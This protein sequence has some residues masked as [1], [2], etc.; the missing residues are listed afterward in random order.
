MLSA[1]G[2]SRNSKTNKADAR[3]RDGVSWMMIILGVVLLICAVLLY[4]YASS[5]SP[6]IRTTNDN[7]TNIN[8]TPPGAGTENSQATPSRTPSSTRTPVQKTGAPVSKHHGSSKDEIY[9]GKK[10]P[11]ASH[12]FLNNVSPPGDRR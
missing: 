5:N 2:D 8:R 10:G 3:G 9:A 4:F 11:A 6:T 7:I 12:E 1:Q